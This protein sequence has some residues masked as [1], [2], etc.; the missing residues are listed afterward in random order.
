MH[1]YIQSVICKNCVIISF[2]LWEY[3]VFYFMVTCIFYR[4]ITMNKG[5]MNSLN[6]MKQLWKNSIVSMFFTP[7]DVDRCEIRCQS[8]SGDYISMLQPP[9][10][11]FSSSF[12]VSGKIG[13]LVCDWCS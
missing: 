9:R 2:Y 13:I 12:N 4:H 11:Y 5:S 8:V 3:L 7:H 6:S 1:Y 10:V